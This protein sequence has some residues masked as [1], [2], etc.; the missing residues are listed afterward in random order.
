MKITIETEV[1]TTDLNN[2]LGQ[3]YLK[4]DEF[5]ESLIKDTLVFELSKIYRKIREA[6]WRN[7]V[8]EAIGEVCKVLSDSFDR[9]INISIIRD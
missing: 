6:D 2:H 7:T 3:G 1:V 8:T 9:K 5:L 4:N